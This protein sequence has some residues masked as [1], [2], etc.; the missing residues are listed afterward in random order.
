MN[1][2]VATTDSPSFVNVTA[3]LTGNAST[4]TTA[5]SA[6]TATTAG[7]VSGTV[8][9]G[10]GGT[11]QT[12]A[13]AAFNA[14]APSQATHSGQFLTTDGTDT[15]WAAPSV[16]AGALTGGTLAAG[17]T[18]SSLTS[19][20]ALNSGS[21]TSGFGSIDTGADSIS[22]TGAVTAGALTFG[23]HIKSTGTT[24][25]L[26]PGNGATGCTLDSITGTDTKGTLTA[27]FV[28]GAATCKINFANSYS[29]TP[30]C[31]VSPTNVVAATQGLT[32]RYTSTTS[33]LT[34]QAGAAVAAGT[35]NYICI[36]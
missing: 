36:E 32:T 15:S 21:I 20:G 24:P 10:N 33:A 16:S 31:I 23:G 7:N 25:A 17:V 11:G 26:D 8:A 34:I 27:T 9:I 35:Y 5:T 18:A 28:D 1:Q 13:N 12:S 4:A 19:V 3:S 29:S 2:G 22:T 6:T 14:L 30:V